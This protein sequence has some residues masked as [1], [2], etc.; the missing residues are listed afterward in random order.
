MK[1][2]KIFLYCPTS[3]FYNKIADKKQARKRLVELKGISSEKLY[4]IY[5]NSY[6]IQKFREIIVA[7]IDEK[8][9]YIL[10]EMFAN[11]DM[12]LYG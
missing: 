11:L 10:E 9:K 7:A 8:N 2:I 4:I 12:H 3:V 1:R 6:E 5:R